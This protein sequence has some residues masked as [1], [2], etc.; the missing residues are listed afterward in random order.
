MPIPNILD[1]AT[2]RIDFNGYIQ[3]L[4]AVNFIIIINFN[5]YL[6]LTY[7]QYLFTACYRS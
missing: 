3:E 5:L 4:L 1:V 7:Q 6:F 2:I